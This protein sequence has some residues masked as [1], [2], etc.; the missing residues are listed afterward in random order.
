[1]PISPKLRMDIFRRDN[2]RCQYCGRSA[3]DVILYVDHWVPV[4][5]GGKDARHNLKTACE[6]CNLGKGDMT[7]PENHSGIPI[8][9]REAAALLLGMHIATN[10]QA[11]PE[12]V[13][14]RRKLAEDAM[15]LLTCLPVRIDEDGLRLQAHRVLWVFT[16]DRD[17][18]DRHGVSDLGVKAQGD[19]GQ[20]NVI[21]IP[22][23][24][25][26]ATA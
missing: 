19:A 12:V 22:R 23:Q 4:S 9:A 20:L 8:N 10:R 5:K 15:T 1:M 17:G 6:C 26:A 3:P 16:R 11:T 25:Q 18:P 14:A 2:H 7:M 24:G 13:A 21:P